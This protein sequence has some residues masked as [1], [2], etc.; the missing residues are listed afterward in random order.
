MCLFPTM[1]EQAFDDCFFCRVVSTVLDFHLQ[2][3]NA[4]SFGLR[5]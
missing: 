2:V 3:V 4:L 1:I 5:K